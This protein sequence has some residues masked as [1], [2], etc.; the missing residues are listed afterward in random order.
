METGESVQGAAV[1]K[2][3]QIGE[4]HQKHY[5]LLRK[6]AMAI[7]GNPEDAEEIVHDVYV[8]VLEA[9]L[10]IR[11]FCRHPKAYLVTCV[12]N[13]AKRFAEKRA[14]AP[15]LIDIADIDMAPIEQVPAFDKETLERLRRVLR[16]MDTRTVTLLG[17]RYAHDYG[18]AE[19]A[20]IL[21]IFRW[22][23]KL[24]LSR[25]RREVEK[26]MLEEEGE[27]E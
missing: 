21:G 15:E 11:E 18:V 3:A 6:I 5:R 13:D 9:D 20:E 4:M 16:K 7:V 12:V 19:V 8:H 27:A 23:A 25:A 1:G 22:S 14:A 26:L 17:L 2:A 24:R 10:P